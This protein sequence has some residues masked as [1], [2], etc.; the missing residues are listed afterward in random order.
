MNHD[1]IA[2]RLN[3]MRGRCKAQWASFV[4][5]YPRLVAGKR[6]EIAGRLQVARAAVAE[7]RA[8]TP[9]SKNGAKSGGGA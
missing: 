1:T 8:T 2:G 4:G 9:I 6:I 3:Q 7:R 5:D